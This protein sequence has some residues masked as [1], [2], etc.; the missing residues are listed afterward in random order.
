MMIGKII[1]HYEILEKIGEGGMGEIYK[2]KDLR[3]K[4][5]VAIKILP[6]HLN[7][8]ESRHLLFINEAQTASALNHPNICSIYDV[9]NQDGVDFIVMEYI[10]GESLRDI[11]NRDKLL[12]IGKVLEFA[13]KICSAL[14]L[15]HEK[16]IIHRDI[17]PDNIMFSADGNFKIMDF[18]LAKLKDQVKESTPEISSDWPTNK[19]LD[20]YKS[21]STLHGTVNYMAP[22]LIKKEAYDDRL[23]IF[24]LGVMLY[25]SLTGKLPFTGKDYIDVLQSILTTETD[26]PSKLNPEITPELDRVILK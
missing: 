6:P 1:S 25:E 10:E 7:L 3:L 9:D 5:F 13:L 15:T 11:L 19:K 21:F 17:K 22:E 20:A 24:S 18:G 8:E 16:G 2:A 26:A 14:K 4:R 12:P 23:D